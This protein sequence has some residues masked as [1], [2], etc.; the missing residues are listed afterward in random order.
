MRREPAVQLTID[1]GSLN[2]G[3]RRRD[4]H[5][6]SRDF[7]DVEQHPEVLFQSDSAVLEGQTLKV[8]GQL[9]ARG[10]QLPLELDATISAA[11]QGLAIEAEAHAVHRNLGMT[12]SPLGM[13]RPHSRLIVKGRL[14]PATGS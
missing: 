5:L 3:N 6:R 1:A 2:T 7:F 4:Q 14:E 9:H 13:T 12:W 11:D 8:Q 10:S